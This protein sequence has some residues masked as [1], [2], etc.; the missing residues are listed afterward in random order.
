[1][2]RDRES[3]GSDQLSRG[4]I[5]MLLY[6]M[7]AILIM[8]FF[9]SNPQDKGV[10]QFYMNLGIIGI[11]FVFFIDLVLVKKANLRFRDVDVPDSVTKEAESPIFGHLPRIFNWIEIILALLIVGFIVF[12]FSKTP[13]LQIVESP[14]FSIGVS[15]GNFGSALLSGIAG[16]LEDLL[17]FGLIPWTFIFAPVMIISRNYWLALILTFL[18]GPWIFMAYHFF[19]YPG[20]QI[21]LNSVLIYGYIFTALVIATGSLVLGSSIHFANNF[22]LTI[23]RQI[24]VDISGYFY[25]YVIAIGIILL[26]IFILKR[27]ARG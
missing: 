1:M 5:F 11:V 3:A 18:I 20:S 21:A 14:Q 22:S 27:R 8:L 25:A 2:S 13:T 19:T 10:S 17:W 26:I 16:T 15:L 4:K 7:V 9:A 24:K 23:F 6:Y 12:N